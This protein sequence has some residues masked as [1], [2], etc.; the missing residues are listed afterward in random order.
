MRCSRRSLNAGAQLQ[1]SFPKYTSDFHALRSLIS[2]C[3]GRA[4]P[5]CDR[6]S[7]FAI[8]LPRGDRMDSS[9]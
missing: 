7:L 6:A 8:Y 4:S 9:S 1:S 5:E 3:F 2:L